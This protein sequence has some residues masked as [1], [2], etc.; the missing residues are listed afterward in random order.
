MPRL[1]PLQTTAL[2]Y[3]LIFNE[4]PVL[5]DISIGLGGTVTKVIPKSVSRAT[6]LDVLIPDRTEDTRPGTSLK[7]VI[8]RDINSQSRPITSGMARLQLRVTAYLIKLT[9]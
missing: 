1:Y 9:K 3:D 6:L 5:D 2:R 8:V 4:I 7:K